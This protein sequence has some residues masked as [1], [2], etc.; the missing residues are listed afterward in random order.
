MQS[1]SAILAMVQTDIARWVL[2]LTGHV[3]DGDFPLKPP[4]QLKASPITD[5]FARH[6]DYD[7]DQPAL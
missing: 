6:Q 1:D 5:L 7:A 3:Q 4:R 2:C